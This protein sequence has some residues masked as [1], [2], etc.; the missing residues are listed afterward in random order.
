MQSD[1][2]RAQSLSDRLLVARRAVR[3]AE[4]QLAT[5]LAE[6]A[7]GRLFQ[8]LG[9]ASLDEYADAVLDLPPRQ[10]RDLLRIG[11]ALPVL[12]ALA[13]ALEAGELDW[14]KAREIVR[15]G[16]SETEAAWVERAKSVT[17]R[18]L[19]REVADSLVGELPPAGEPRPERRPPRSRMVLELES[20]DHEIFAT[21]L[22][23][24]AA[25]LGTDGVEL[26][27]SALVGAAARMVV[28]QLERDDAL[29]IDAPTGERYRVVIDHCPTCRDNTIPTL[30]GAHEVSDTIAAEAACDAE[31]VEMRPGPAQGHAT[32]AIP[33]AVRRIVLNR[34]KWRCEVPYCRGRLWLDVHHLQ[35]WA[36]GG[37]HAVVN[38]V[39]VCSCH[40]RAIHT[41]TL[42][43]ERGSDGRIVVTR[44]DGR[45]DWESDPRGAGG[46]VRL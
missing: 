4:H 18:V 26:D 28:D 41:G 21:M 15:V 3:R 35:H 12:P 39:A 38:L 16:T 46:T 8:T 20:A 36:R 24:L 10:V 30:G 19:E 7:E 25:H 34:A 23:L 9:Y 13:A 14:T 43:V 37:T 11:R 22:A 1:R 33:P 5:L 6:L 32:R 27:R 44:W 42:A 45:V 31:I 29:E 40:H 2:A 17:S